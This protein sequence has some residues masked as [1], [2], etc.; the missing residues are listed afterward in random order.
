[1]GGVSKERKLETDA[2]EQTGRVDSSMDEMCI[3]HDGAGS[4]PHH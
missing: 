4:L 1:M 3:Q 2:E